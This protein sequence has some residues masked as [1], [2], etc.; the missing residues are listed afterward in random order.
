MEPNTIFAIAGI[1]LLISWVLAIAKQYYLAPVVL[2]SGSAF[3]IIM[4]FAGI[5]LA[6]MTAGQVDPIKFANKALK[7]A[8]VQAV[9]FMLIVT[10]T[11]VYFAALFM[12]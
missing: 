1:T 2:V 12:F 3:Y 5:I 9:A 6:V 10:A 8:L 11:I 7:M 4:C